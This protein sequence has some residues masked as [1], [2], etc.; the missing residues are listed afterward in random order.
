MYDRDEIEKLKQMMN[1]EDVLRYLGFEKINTVK[2]RCQCKIH[3]GQNANSFS[4][5]NNLF[6]CFACHQSGDVIDLIKIIHRCDFKMALKI[7]ESITGYNLKKSDISYK[8]KNIY[9][10]EIPELL[11]K[12]YK[13]MDYVKLQIEDEIKQLELRKEEITSEMNSMRHE[14]E[15]FPDRWKK[16]EEEAEEIQDRIN[17]LTFYLKKR[18]RSNEL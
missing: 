10:R 18:S 14:V 13:E 5:N 2:R 12:R 17:E 1:W 15:Y 3:G 11:A 7:M 9:E 8:K 16:L 6:Y 4:W